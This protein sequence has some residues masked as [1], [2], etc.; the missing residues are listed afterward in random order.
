[1][2]FTVVPLVALISAAL[3]FSA[4]QHSEAPTAPPF[5]LQ[6]LDGTTI[7]LSKLKGKVV[8][9]NF[10]A[11]WCG[12]C[13]SEIPGFLQ[14]YKE[15]RG[16]G[17]EIVG[18]SLDD[19]SDDEVKQFVQRYRIDYPIGKDD[20]SIAKLYGGIQAIPTTFFIDRTGRIVGRHIGF[21]SKEQFAM[22]IK[23]LL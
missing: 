9:L 11:T 23:K 1:M 12:P 18:L 19:A 8:V 22:T 15:T 7:E 13:R 20:G 16:K 5:R 2:T 17:V 21:M 4:A 14:V 6:T 10:W 3:L